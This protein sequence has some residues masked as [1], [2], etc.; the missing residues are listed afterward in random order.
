[1]VSIMTLPILLLAAVTVQDPLPVR[2]EDTAVER[3][4]N[5]KV[6]E[7][8]LLDGMEDP[9][10]W[11]LQGKGEM[12]FTRE[13]AKE[14]AQSV[15]LRARTKGDKPAAT[16]GRPFGSAGV[17]RKFP[18]EDWTKFNRLSFWVYPDLPGFRVVSL[19]VRLHNEGA[20]RVPDA[21]GREGLNFMILRNHEWNHLVWEIAH[22]SR[23]KVTGVEFQ[24][25]QQGNEPGAAETVQFDIDKL[26]LERVDADHFEGWNVAPGQIAFSHTGYPLGARKTA[27][28]S[29]LKA[30][31]FRL[32]RQETGRVVLSKP[33]KTVETRLGKFQVLDFSEAREPGAYVLEAGGVKTR[34]F[35][36]EAN[37]W[38]ET[39]WKVINFFYTERCGTEIPGIHGVCH[40]D[41]QAV[42]GD[43]RILI[44]GGWHDAGDLSQGLVNTS[45]AVYSMLALAERLQDIDPELARRLVEEA[46][47]GLDWVLKT[48]FHDGYR[49][50][51][52]THD[53]WTN[54][55][56]GDVDDVTSEA[57]K[58]PYENYLAASSEAIAYRTLNGRDPILARHALG[59]AEEDWRFAVESSAGERRFGAAV[60]LAGAGVLASLEL[61]QATG[62]AEYRNKALELGQVIVDSQQRGVPE[63]WKVPLK[64]FFYTSPAKDRILHYVHRG[65]EQSP[66]VALVRLC[67]ALPDHPDRPKWYSAVEL[68]SEYLKAMAKFTEPWGMLPA[69]VYRD[70]EYSQVPENRRET[71]QRQVRNGIPVGEHHYLRLFPV[72]F[73][74]RGNHGTMLSQTKAL[75]AAGRLRGDKESIELAQLQLEWVV[76]RN[77]FVESTMYGEGSGYAPQ[78]TAM[79]GDLVGSLPVGIQ[80][81]GERDLPYWPAANCYNYKEVWVHPASRWLWILEDLVR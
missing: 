59:T 20:E 2:Q 26:E 78:Y 19:L 57:R 68:H 45:E 36:I 71:F 10:A 74:Y 65:H 28:A 17:F 49:V 61:L 34:P 81:R 52:A 50:T 75:A 46:K 54:G 51:W 55:I 72:W 7:S 25:R 37:V 31:E 42:H 64:G 9:A 53:F 47:W 29:D 35:R 39:V 11:V 40:R 69:S 15:R 18:G 66:I 43:K 70:D 56:L 4:L 41:W 73:D 22:L 5:K 80:T 44:N 14:G 12:T 16:M 30:R 27:L 38:N 58:M 77:P 3:W 60:E 13:R 6:L 24:Y 48:S 32:I 67:R 21:Y 63:G 76:G 23:D 8:R 62:R 33:V 1:M 79:S